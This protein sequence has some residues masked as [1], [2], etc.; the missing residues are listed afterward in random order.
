MK[1]KKYDSSTNWVKSSWMVKW[2]VVVV[3]VATEI[4][5][6]RLTGSECSEYIVLFFNITWLFFGHPWSR[7]ICGESIQMGF[8]FCDKIWLSPNALP[9][10]YIVTDFKRRKYSEVILFISGANV[11][12]FTECYFSEFPNL[13]LVCCIQSRLLS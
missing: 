10:Y 8:T 9:T 5:V 12:V 6:N 3:I 4:V 2:S 13:D 1:A 11:Y 7:V